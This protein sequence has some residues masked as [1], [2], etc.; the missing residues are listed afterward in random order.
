MTLAADWI[1]ANV[2]PDNAELRDALYRKYFGVSEEWFRSHGAGE[3]E[4]AQETLDWVGQM[5]CRLAEMRLA[6]LA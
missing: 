2:L 6:Q 5:A 4:E 3:A 1:A